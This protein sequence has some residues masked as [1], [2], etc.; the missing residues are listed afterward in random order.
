M[1]EYLSTSHLHKN[2]RVSIPKVRRI[3]YMTID[4][5]IS[6]SKSNEFSRKNLAN[7]TIHSLINSHKATYFITTGSRSRHPQPELGVLAG[8]LTVTSP[9]A[10]MLAPPLLFFVANAKRRA[11][12]MEEQPMRYKLI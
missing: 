6:Y 8:D 5:Y 12:N 3:R 7:L 9:S 4:I 11:S 10:G 1:A 2:G